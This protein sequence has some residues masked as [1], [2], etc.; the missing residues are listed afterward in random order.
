MFGVLGFCVDTCPKTQG[1]RRTDSIYVLNPYHEL[2][3]LVWGNML[4]SA[5]RGYRSPAEVFDSPDADDQ[6]DAEES[7]NSETEVRRGPGRPRVEDVYGPKFVDFIRTYVNTRGKMALTDNGRM[8]DNSLS[9]FTAPLTQIAKAA[10]EH[11]FPLV[12]ETVRRLFKPKRKDDTKGLQRGVVDAR[13]ASIECSDSTW[14]SRCT[15]SACRVKLA[16]QFLR[17]AWAGGVSIAQYHL[18]ECS[19]FPIW[20]AARKRS[21]R[22]FPLPQV[23]EAL[24]ASPNS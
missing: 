23:I 13:R 3:P 21:A 12:P 2:G 16:E 6:Q 7:D 4:A 10:A 9:V 18:D 24:P 14:G 22:P 11:N 5:R 8:L 1:H 20:T 15:F 19:K 17:A